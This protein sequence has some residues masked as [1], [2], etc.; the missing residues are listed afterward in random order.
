MNPIVRMKT[1]RSLQLKNK[2]IHVESWKGGIS[3]SKKWRIGNREH[4]GKDDID[5]EEDEEDKEQQYEEDYFKSVGLPNEEMMKWRKLLKN[6]VFIFKSKTSG[7]EWMFHFI[8]CMEKG[9]L[10]AHKQFWSGCSPWS[11]SGRWWLETKI[12][13]L[14]GKSNNTVT[15]CSNKASWQIT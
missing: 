15:P 3:P 13:N 8:S 2:N 14:F 1:T 5:E 10:F 4:G 12:K 6:D 9:I 11:W 7:W